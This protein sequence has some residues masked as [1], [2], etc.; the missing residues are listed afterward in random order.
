MHSLSNNSNTIYEQIFEGCNFCILL[1]SSCFI[2]ED[3]QFLLSTL[4]LHMHCIFFKKF[5]G[6]N[7]VDESA[8]TAK[9]RPSKFVCIRYFYL[10]L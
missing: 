1:K 7:F 8:I 5:R 4:V 10:L 9:L 6:F 3:H 2:F